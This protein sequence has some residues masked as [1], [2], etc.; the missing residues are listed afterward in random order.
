MSVVGTR[1]GAEFQKR[2]N[3]SG[4]HTSETLHAVLRGRIKGLKKKIDWNLDFELSRMMPKRKKN[5]YRNR[6]E[7]STDLVHLLEAEV[8]KDGEKASTT[9]RHRPRRPSM[10]VLEAGRDLS[11]N[12]LVLCSVPSSS[13]LSAS[14]P[15]TT[16][17][18]DDI[19]FGNIGQTI[20]E[21]LEQGHVDPAIDSSSL[22][23]D[24]DGSF[25]T[26]PLVLPSLETAKEF[27]QNVRR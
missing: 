8:Q 1:K 2:G 19:L 4:T 13:S 27:H 16:V 20:T 17:A 26:G 11:F 25:S 18:L 6:G 23:P 15:S 5:R 14:F 3:N 9:D 21:L 10:N 24:I 12:S 22:A 7:I